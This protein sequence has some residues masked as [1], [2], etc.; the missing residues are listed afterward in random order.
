MCFISMYSVLNVLSE[1]TYFYISKSITP[2][3][4][5][6]VFKIV[7]RLQCILKLKG[8]FLS[9]DIWISVL[10]ILVM[11]ENDLIRKQRLIS[12][13]MTSKTGKQI[14]VIHILPNVSRSKDNQTKK[15]VH[16]IEYNIRN[17]NPKKTKCGAEVSSRPFSKK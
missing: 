4:F 3:T 1:Y 12:I 5:L 17:F 7:E 2:Y 16:L 14:T 6:L 11:F 8:F 15:F 13:F 10:T 9:E